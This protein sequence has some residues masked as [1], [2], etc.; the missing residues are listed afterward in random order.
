MK[1]EMI[2]L[3][4]ED[5]EVRGGVVGAVFIYMVD[6][7]VCEGEHGGNDLSSYSLALA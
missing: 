5:H 3:I 1:A 2:G 7:F 6:D 4:S